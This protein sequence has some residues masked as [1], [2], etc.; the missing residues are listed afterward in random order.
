MKTINNGFFI[1]KDGKKHEGNRFEIKDNFAK[2]FIN[3]KTYFKID[4]VDLFPVIS[5]GK[6][7][8]DKGGYISCCNNRLH[9]YLLG[10]NSCITFLNMDKTDCRRGNLVEINKSLV[11]QTRYSLNKNNKSGYRGVYW[12]NRDKRWVVSVSIKK[13]NKRIPL[14]IGSYIDLHE[15]GSVSKYARAYLYKYAKDLKEYTKTPF[16]IKKKIDKA[17]NNN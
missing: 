17:L 1:S 11:G 12:S 13:S 16:W 3:K 14:R 6:W 7:N 4:L 8:L 15:A 9:S 5:F 2:V 10:K